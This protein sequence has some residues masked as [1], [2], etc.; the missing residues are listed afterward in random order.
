MDDRKKE[1]SAYYDFYIAYREE[2]VAQIE[3]AE[4][5]LEVMKEYLKDRIKL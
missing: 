1:L 4:T 5:V 2:A 3:T